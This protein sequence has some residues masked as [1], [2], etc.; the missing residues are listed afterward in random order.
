MPARSS[1]CRLRSRL[2]L[3]APPPPACSQPAVP[4]PPPLP[5]VVALTPTTVTLRWQPSAEGGAARYSVYGSAALNYQKVYA[6][7]E[8]ECTVAGLSPGGTYGFRVCALNALG[9]ASEFSA[10]VPATTPT[11][12]TEVAEGGVQQ[13][14]GEAAAAA[15]V[16]L[17]ALTLAHA[18]ESQLLFEWQPPS[19]AAAA[20]QQSSELAVCLRTRALDPGSRV[21][22]APPM[23][24]QA[25]TL[26]AGDGRGTAADGGAVCTGAG[27]GLP[28]FRRFEC[29]LV[30]LEGARPAPG[31]GQA[32]AGGGGG[33]RRVEGG[34]LLAEGPAMLCWTA[35][36]AP[37]VPSVLQHR[38]KPDNL[39][40]RWAEPVRMRLRIH[41]LL[42]LLTLLGVLVLLLLLLVLLPAVCCCCSCC[43]LLLL[44]L[45]LPLSAPVTPFGGAQGWRL[46]GL[47]CGWWSSPHTR[48]PSS[49]LLP[50]LPPPPPASLPPSP[51]LG[52]PMLWL[53]ASPRLPVA[54][55]LRVCPRLRVC[56]R[57][58]VRARRR[59]AR[60]PTC[61][62]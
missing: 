27:A 3:R 16:K 17:P 14:S 15:G 30:S 35:P 32:G 19:G 4:V 54:R 33:L 40:M 18:D 21:P 34:R 51:K 24:S 26:G 5:E 8:C 2:S 11:A 53:R 37:G 12:E 29:A 1:R 6:G 10:E 62:R 38:V 58:C 50:F 48:T 47:E 52:C 60:C 13:P 59:V 45:L 7:A 56:A 46:A 20:T 42:L 41:A 43:L 44:L 57:G 25:G 49:H 55:C 28:P 31:G 22:T 39:A 23:F 9:G 36:G 61:W